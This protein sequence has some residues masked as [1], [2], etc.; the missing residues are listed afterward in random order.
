[1]R[2]LRRLGRKHDD[3][4]LA[5]DEIVTGERLQA[6]ADISLVPVHVYEFHR[7]VARFAREMVVFTDHAG[8][9]DEEIGR[10]SAKRSLFVYTHELDAFIEHVWPR[11]TGH[12][13][14]LITHNSDHGVDASRLP[15]LEATGGKLAH[16]FAQNVVVSHPKLTPL[17]IGVANSMWPHGDLRVLRRAMSRAAEP[18]PELVFLQFN[19]KTHHA[20]QQ[21]WDTLRGNFPEMGEEP[22]PGRSFRRYLYDLARHRFT[23]APRGNGIDTHRVWESLYL[24]VSPILERSAHTEHWHDAGLPLVL[25]DDWA[26]V[27]PSF[28]AE[29]AGRLRDVP[30]A[31][32]ALRLS[33]YTEMIAAAVQAPPRTTWAEPAR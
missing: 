20:R 8:L 17:P 2:A 4:A 11:L 6:L 1:M 31:D 15:W 26:Q 32:S 22:P 23:V 5:E 12:G 3:G 13:Y 25:V 7:H 19:P 29:Q 18:R 28:L 9:G 33:T 10:I 21:T 16:W 27:T 30:S 24:G 14:V